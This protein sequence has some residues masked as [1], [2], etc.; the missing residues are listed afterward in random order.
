MNLTNHT[1]Q[2]P[3]N[4]QLKKRAQ[5]NGIR[6]AVVN[7]LAEADVISSLFDSIIVLQDTSQNQVNENIIISIDLV[8]L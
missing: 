5:K 6:H 1:E 7:N 3:I 4:Q 8:Y 2:H